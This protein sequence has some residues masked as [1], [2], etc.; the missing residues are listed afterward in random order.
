M[1][2]RSREGTTLFRRGRRRAERKPDEDAWYRQVAPLYTQPVRDDFVDVGPPPTGAA[3][4]LEET[5][6]E[7]L[8]ERDTAPESVVAPDAAIEQPADDTPTSA[9]EQ[10]AWAPE[11]PV[12]AS[13]FPLAGAVAPV[14]PVA[15]TDP[16]APPVAA[17]DPPPA[18]PVAATDPPAPGVAAPE[19]LPHTPVPHDAG[20]RPA[21]DP[22]MIIP[23][24]AYYLTRA[25]DTLRS[26]AAQF[27]NTPTRWKDLRSLNAAYPGIASAGPD[28]LLPIGSSL[29]LPGDPLPWGRPDPVYLWTLAEKF[30]YTAWGREPSPEEVVPFWR[31]LTSGAQRLETGAPP[32]EEL[33]AI[34]SAPTM[35][36]APL[37][38]AAPVAPEP[39]VAPAPPS[40]APVAEPAPETPAPPA[41]EPTLAAPEAPAPEAPAP[42]PAPEPAAPVYAPPPEPAP[43][44]AAEPPPA[45][46]VAE[47]APEPALPVYAPPPPPSAP[48]VVD[49]PPP[50][51]AVE[52]PVAESAPPAPPPPAAPVVSEPAVAPAP[53]PSAPAAEPV[54]E[55]PAPLAPEPPLAAP[56]APAPEPPA[57]TPA[58]APA[59][60]VYAPPPPP[61]APAEAAEP[62]PAPAVE[63][64]SEPAAPVAESPVAESPAPA[65]PVYA[66]P[67]P[68][69]PVVADEPPAVEP[70]SDPPAPP[71]PAPA[72][73]APSVPPPPAYEPVAGLPD[74]GPIEPEAP[75]RPETEAP[76]LPTF[77]PSMTGANP[78][79]QLPVEEV[80]ARSQRSLAGT[81][82]GD[83]MML[84]Q[85]GR[86]RRRGAK[87]IQAIP[88]PIEQ[89]LEQSARM[90][91]LR[92]IEAAM[93][94]LRSVTVAQ[95]R[96]KP[97][98]MCVR[99]GTYG[100]EVLLD[101]PVEAPEGWALA[102]GG[103]V[104][105]LPRSVTVEELDAV[106][107]GPSLCPA[108]VPVGDTVEGPLLLN[109]EEI[110]CLAV[111]GP[112][113]PAASLLTSIV[114][115][116]GSSPLAGDVRI[117]TVGVSSP[118]GP[119]WERIHAIG[120]DSPRLEHL[121]SAAASP[122]QADSGAPLDVL[123]VGPGHDLL[124]QR[125][126]QIAITPG[127][128]LALV[129]ATSSAAARW[130]WRI[131]VDAT[132]KAIIHPI[133][134]TMIAAQAMRP[135]LAFLLSETSD[136]PPTP[137]R[138]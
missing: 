125:A 13:E 28:T 114:E 107:Q 59:P 115:T 10:S 48:V 3:V 70:V 44:E 99:V 122:T 76:P 2:W 41:P 93:R 87:Q 71:A 20:A 98:V 138:T 103:Y 11:Q 77:M 38:P 100:F 45:A 22:P 104:L 105:E 135:E 108:L 55:P 81:A 4:K 56:E 116:L 85:L 112:S 79:A 83:A 7:V 40:A 47:P 49:E 89:S 137:A 35:P 66:P 16:P 110:G 30:L 109:I 69:A 57:P 92:L 26:I 123:V 52:P 96:E 6:V 106:G 64:V 101:Q 15:A 111:S 12:A 127:S 130:P 72:Y 132:T 97:R 51:P 68:S 126:G 84:W 18:P 14:A 23:V 29:A 67:P 65:P 121:L 54:S 62:P 24:R 34:A 113:A 63:P 117:V 90:D 94:Q 42:T 74:L 5:S 17:T 43:A 32:P 91:S 124:I 50:A 46:P 80:V 88:D 133:S 37:P 31:G 131:H 136:T 61:P 9:P 118:V 82:I 86:L 8:L 36:P 102:S 75:Y 119:G 60:P 27:L 58:P 129:G 39:A 78:S 1:R 128:G 73:T 21:V 134:C 25:D 53:P 95:L 120:F 33:E 19:P